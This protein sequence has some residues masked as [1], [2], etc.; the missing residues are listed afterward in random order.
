MG[1]PSCKIML[2]VLIE[3]SG[4]VS[5][6]LLNKI[7]E[8]IITSKSAGGMNISYFNADT[9]KD[10]FAYLIMNKCNKDHNTN[11]QLNKIYH[12]IPIDKWSEI[13]KHVSMLI[14][15]CTSIYKTTAETFK[16]EII[17]L[18][19]ENNLNL[20]NGFN[21]KNSQLFELKVDTVNNTLY[22]VEDWT[23]RI[24]LYVLLE[25]DCIE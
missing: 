19:L 10:S 1:I 21:I 7:E 4:I 6:V 22:L 2:N 16:S 14:F 12:Y 23:E 17:D 3:K 8:L 25:E 20:E 11:E 5:P 9:G 13:L 15:L 24:G 18:N